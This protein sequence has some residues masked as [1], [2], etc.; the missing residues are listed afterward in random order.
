MAT[1]F[2]QREGGEPLAAL[3]AATACFVILALIC[4]FTLKEIE[5]P[6]ARL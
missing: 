6:A 5:K 4:F 1:I 3:A 2:E